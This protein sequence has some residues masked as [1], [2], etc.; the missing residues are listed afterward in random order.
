VRSPNSAH[1]GHL[2]RSACPRGDLQHPC[3][4]GRVGPVAADIQPPPNRAPGQRERR[5]GERPC[6]G[7][8]DGVGEVVEQP[9][10]VAEEVGGAHQERHDVAFGDG[11]DQRQEFVANSIATKARIGVGRIHHRIELQDGA[12]PSRFVAS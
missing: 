5:R 4:G 6:I 1:A 3:N 7:W 2:T 8:V 10:I 9:V 12:E 11:I